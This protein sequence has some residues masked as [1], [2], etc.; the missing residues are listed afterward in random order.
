MSNWE[1][2]SNQNID[3]AMILLNNKLSNESVHCSYY[4]CVQYVFHVFCAAWGMDVDEV[5]NNS[6]SEF[7]RM[8]TH[9]WL[10]KEIFK[11][12]KSKN[13]SDAKRFYDDMGEMSQIRANADYNHDNVGNLIAEEVKTKAI[14]V[15]G[16]LK[17]HYEL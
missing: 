17:K 1:N 13:K 15:L 12:M 4:S 10:R 16:S 5:E 14:N 6:H 9:K 8:G 3:A 11:S 7:N 2:K